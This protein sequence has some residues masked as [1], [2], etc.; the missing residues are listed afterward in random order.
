MVISIVEI[1]NILLSFRIWD[2]SV[3]FVGSNLDNKEKISK[4]ASTGLYIFSKSE[5]F[6]TAGEKMIKNRKKIKNE[7]YISE[8]YNMLLKV[9]AQFEIDIAEEFV[10]F[11]TPEDIKKFEMK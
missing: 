9:N 11:G 3:K 4:Y 5:Q 7:Y 2:T 8:I 10:P 1:C 6:F